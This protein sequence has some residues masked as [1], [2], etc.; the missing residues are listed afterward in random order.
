M[1]RN[2][3]LQLALDAMRKNLRLYVPYLVTG[4][5]MV[6][7][8]YILSYLC[9]SPALS[10][11]EGGGVLRTMLSM[12]CWIIALFSGIFLFYTN[13]FVLR[14]RSKEFG[15]YSI[16]GMD[17]R[18][19]SRIIL[20]EYVLVCGI[21]IFGGLI[22]G[23]ALSKLAELCMLNIMDAAVDYRLRV[24]WVSLRQTL[25][26]FSGIYLFLLLFAWIR[27]TRIHPI[28]LLRS[29]QAGEKPPKANWVSA[30]LGALV[31]G[32]AYRLAVSVEQPITA[33]I[34]FFVAVA[35]VII[36]TYLLF[37]AGSVTLCRLLQKNRRYYY[38]PT[39]FVSVSSMA[40]RMKRNGAGL[41]SICILC[42]MVLVILSSTASLYI[43]AEDALS[44]QYPRDITL[45]LPILDPD[46]FHKETVSQMRQ[47]VTDVV[48]EQKNRLEY[49]FAETAGLMTE[50]GF[51]MDDTSDFD[52]GLTT[53]EDIGYLT[54]LSLDE[55]N[56]LTGE[57]HTLAADEC[58]L[59]CPQR[60]FTPATFA[61]EHAAP[62]RVK[63]VS[64]ES[65][66]PGYTATQITAN[67]LLV[68]SDL[69]SMVQPLLSMH[70]PAGTPLLRFFWFYGFDMDTDGQTQI[71]AYTRL[72][73]HIRTI[74]PPA[75]DTSY[76]YRL[77]CREAGRIDFFGTYSS[78]FF[79]GIMLSFVFLFAA[80]LIIY[81]KQICEGYEDRARFAIMQKVGMTRQDIRK[82]INSQILTVFFAP[83]LFAGLHLA[84]AFPMVWKLLQLFSFHDQQLVIGVTFCSFLVFG[85]FYTLVYRMTANA[86]YH[87]VSDADR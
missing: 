56:R 82:S 32:A 6:M 25:L 36:A 80:V 3:Y 28:N 48:S 2:L 49:T 69:D 40:Y 52:F 13:S 63:A 31:L 42:T 53:Y 15:L 47:V 11:M 46:N 68:V 21:S 7:M 75:P 5:V 9:Q 16:L 34:W 38:H 1:K 73:E 79:L 29:E 71:A 26:L 35:L 50:T 66:F 86:Y 77:D 87:I 64:H 33:L 60:D 58:L 10:H 39:H 4:S 83:L 23:T 20:G 44:S 76:S 59:I 62:L 74:L 45:Q 24:D 18:N 12:G 22:L 19:I 54:I 27:V 14:R 43:G 51:I 70:D 17:K 65:V 67:I 37:I 55:Y 41:A 81:Y 8:H 30:F 61:V 57:V 84:F 85:L 78:L 72:Q